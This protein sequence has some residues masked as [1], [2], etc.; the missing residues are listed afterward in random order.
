MR[1]RLRWKPQD[2]W[3][4]V[5]WRRDRRAGMFVDRG[6]VEWTERWDVWVCLLPMLPIHLSWRKSDDASE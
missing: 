6:W 2:C 1:L 4:G 3:V 5:F